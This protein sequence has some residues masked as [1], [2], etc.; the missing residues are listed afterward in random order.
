[1][2]RHL[3]RRCA[4]DT[5]CTTPFFFYAARLHPRHTSCTVV[6]QT[7]SPEQRSELWCVRRAAL[8]YRCSLR[9]PLGSSDTLLRA[10]RVWSAGVPA[11][12][13]AGLTQSGSSRR[14]Q[15]H[16]PGASGPK[17]SSL[18]VRAADRFDERP[19][20]AK[21]GR[22]SRATRPVQSQQPSGPALRSTLL[23]NKVASASSESRRVPLMMLA[24][25][26]CQ[27]TIASL[28]DN[29]KIV[30]SRRWLAH[31]RPHNSRQSCAAVVRGRQDT[32]YHPYRLCALILARST[33]ILAAST[34]WSLHSLL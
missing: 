15:T 17:V 13:C 3:R 14:C 10:E 18:A 28:Y 5:S 8:F 33:A 23:Q 4:L 24:Y 31:H 34:C 9:L 6:L 30:A 12:R 20:M 1:M 27:E 2:Q 25:D 22:P 19:G 21:R 16:M 29:A 11:V 7:S 32:T 26:H